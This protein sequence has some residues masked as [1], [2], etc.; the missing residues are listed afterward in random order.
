M[1]RQAHTLSGKWPERYNSLPW[2]QM[3]D[4][5]WEGAHVSHQ[6]V[7]PLQLPLPRWSSDNMWQRP[8]YY[9]VQDGTAPCGTASKQ[10]RAS[11]KTNHISRAICGQSTPKVLERQSMPEI[12]ERQ[13]TPGLMER[14]STP[15]LLERQSMAN[16]WNNRYLKAQGW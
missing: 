15:E 14:Q 2:L 5:P 9:I 6:Q 8:R 11:W 16:I 1:K 13:S 4:L 7:L 12:F 3:H 10:S